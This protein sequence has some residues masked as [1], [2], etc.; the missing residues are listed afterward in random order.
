MST[1]PQ[2]TLPVRL[3]V[4]AVQ[5][6]QIL[7]V[8]LKHGHGS[9]RFI[10]TCSAYMIQALQLHGPL[11]GLLLGLRRLLKCHPFGPYGYDPVPLPKQP[12]HHPHE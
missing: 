4:S 12:T 6:Y 7:S 8:P 3:M 11:K 10:P 5:A 2:N 9:C 1:N